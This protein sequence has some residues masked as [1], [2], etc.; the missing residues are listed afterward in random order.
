MDLSHHSQS[1]YRL[2][3]VADPSG[4][5]GASHPVKNRYV[6]LNQYSCCFHKIIKYL[7]EESANDFCNNTPQEV[8][9][10][11]PHILNESC[12]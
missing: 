8:E 11:S 10:K 12:T 1:L 4:V 7:S 6:R 3:L 9:F 5:Y 2:N